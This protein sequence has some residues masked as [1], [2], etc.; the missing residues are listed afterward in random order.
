MKRLTSFHTLVLLCASALLVGVTLVHVAP[1]ATAAPPVPRV[2]KMSSTNYAMDWSAVGEISGG[3]SASTN[4]KLT[5]TIGQMA[6]NMNS[7]SA[8]YQACTGFECVLNSL[9][10]FLPLIVR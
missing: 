10:L 4:F 5:A 8:N 3:A 9:R 7:A 2:P 6:A 1:T